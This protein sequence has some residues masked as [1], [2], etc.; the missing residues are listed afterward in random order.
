M[1]QL[2]AVVVVFAVVIVLVSRKWPMGYAMG[3]GAALLALAAGIGPG[4]LF[5]SIR[6]TV[7][8][9]DT[10]ELAATVA[11]ISLMARLMR[12]FGLLE[13]MT[14][15]LVALLRNVKLAL[16]LVPGLL[17]CLPVFGGAI[18]SAPMVD[19]LGDQLGLDGTRKAAV[20]LVFRHAW[21][22]L[23]PFMPSLIL[24]AKLGGVSVGSVVRIQF[25]LTVVA[26]VS[27]YVYLF[28][29]IARPVKPSQSGASESLT[30]EVAATAAPEATG[31]ALTRFLVSAAPLLTSIIL[32]VAFGL[33][34]VFAL[35]VAVVLTILL[36]ARHPKCRPATI[37]RAIDWM[38][39]L[40]MFSIM[41]FKGVLDRAGFVRSLVASLAANGV[42]PIVLFI[43]LPLLTGFTSGA[44]Q[45]S[46]SI[47]LPLLLPL[48]GANVPGAV[49]VIYAASFLGYFLS[50]LH[51]CL[52]LTA[53]FF[54]AKMAAVYRKSAPVVAVVAAGLLALVALTGAGLR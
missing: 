47:S 30:A 38:L 17:G 21:F 22:F 54:K 24:A 2:V 9:L 34:L 19:A 40:T 41:L 15:S 25:P 32:S 11:L 3:L 48:A 35:T 8:T 20:N 13:Q 6:Q 33:R 16:A 23:F 14:Q 4:G 29:G 12:E 42:P 49:A 37:W 1:L 51:L 28:R 10:Y 7:S 5:A 36:G 45:A 39:V 26:L 44:Q 43:G 53:Q 18:M 46:L 52:V 31:P 27:G 50:P